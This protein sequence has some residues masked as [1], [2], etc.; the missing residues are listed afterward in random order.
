ME[1]G[2]PLGRRFRALKL[3]FVMSYYGREGVSALLRDH[4]R[5]AK[6]LSAKV[7]AHP[8]FAISAPTLFSVVCL[9]LRHSN[10]ATLKLYEALNASGEVFLSKTLLGGQV[11]LRV[12]IGNAGTTQQDV[13][14]VWALIQRKAAAILCKQA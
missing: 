5:W 3:W 11:V 9:R 1:Y 7:A 10:E 2:I 4:I 13:D 12:A 8:D 6:E 14:A